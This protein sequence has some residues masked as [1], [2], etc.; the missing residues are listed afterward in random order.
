MTLIIKG[1]ERGE[2]WQTYADIADYVSITDTMTTT[3]LS[4]KSF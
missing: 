4:K 3:A 2:R 1:M